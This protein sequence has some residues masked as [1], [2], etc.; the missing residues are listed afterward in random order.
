MRTMRFITRIMAHHYSQLFLIF[1]WGTIGKIGKNEN[2][3]QIVSQ[4][5]NLDFRNL[6]ITFVQR[7]ADA[8]HL[9]TVRTN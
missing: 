9:A 1:P 4:D 6:P 7:I 5:P 8:L 2:K 3:S